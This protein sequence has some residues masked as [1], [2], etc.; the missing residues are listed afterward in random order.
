MQTD[1]FMDTSKG[2]RLP[3]RRSWYVLALALFVLSIIVQQPLLFLAALFSLVVGIVPGWWYHQALR[4]LLVRQQVN[5][6]HLFCGEEVV[7]T[8]SIE[9][10]KLFPVPWLHVADNVTPLLPV[11]TKDSSQRENVGQLAN[12]WVLWPLQ[13]VTR[14]YRMRC[15]AR[16]CYTFGPVT[17]STSDPFG[18]L[19]REVTVPLYDTLLVYPLLA[20]P[21]AFGLAP[22]HP[23]GEE[24][25]ARHLLEDPLR[26]R[27]VR[28]YQL[29]DDPR[30]IHWKAT[31]HAGALRSKLYEYSTQQRVLLLLDT[32]NASNL[33]TEMDADMQEFCI[34]AAAS[35]AVWALDEGYMVGLLTNCAIRTLSSNEHAGVRHTT[36]QD[37]SKM[38]EQPRTTEL[39]APGVSVPF[40]CDYG[41]YEHLLATFARLVPYNNV[42]LEN[43][44]ELGDALFFPGTTVILVSAATTLT[45]ATI[46]RLLD[47]RTRGIAL[48]L[49]LT[50]ELEGKTT[51]ETYDIPV[52]YLGGREQWHELIKAF[53]G[54]KSQGTGT[55]AVQLPLD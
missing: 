26:V 51:P 38:P 2:K 41:Q 30:R 27:G 9:N 42:P 15:A 44:I 22:L 11:L 47:M 32:G 49:V 33:W 46:E 31:A 37:A 12:A 7:L 5:P 29:G 1:F 23:Y 3:R 18:W 8:W 17:L 4:H 54:E 55:R 10:Q 35:L 21:A 52:H 50:G 40:A 28:D 43:I 34:A 48:H 39:S 36:T 19:E 6:Q 13:R 24:A 20:P 45:Q 25:T 53:I 16:G 14:R